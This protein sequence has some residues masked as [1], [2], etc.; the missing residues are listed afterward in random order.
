MPGGRS[1]DSRVSRGGT[2]RVKNMGMCNAILRGFRKDERGTTS[3]EYA[4]I[5]VIASIAMIAGAYGTR[6][7]INGAMNNASAGLQAANK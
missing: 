4:L 6:D 7:G 3:T 2:S 1:G 5:A